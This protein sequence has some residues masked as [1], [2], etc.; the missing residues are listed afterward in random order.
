LTEASSGLSG[1]RP[2]FLRRPRSPRAV[3]FWLALWLAVV[4]NLALWRELY[5]VGGESAM[6]V[7]AAPAHSS[8]SSPR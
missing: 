4:G 2:D 1:P 6:L 7:S 5:R 8:S 3:A